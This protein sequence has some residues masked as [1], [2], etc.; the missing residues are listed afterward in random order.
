MTYLIENVS[1]ILP[2]F[3]QHLILTLSVIFFTLLIGVP[4]GVLLARKK[5]LRAPVL[6]FLGIVY[7]IPSLSFFILLLPVFGLGTRS[8][9]IA[10]T[11]Y[12]QLLFIRNWLTGLT[13]ID[14]SI[15]EAAKGMGM[16]GRRRFW[17]VEFPLSLPMFLAGVRLVALSSI[18]IG[19]I[20]AFIHAG[21]LGV[22]L[23]Q[24]VITANYGKIS[25]GA[26]CVSFLAFGV[27][28]GI[29]TL[30]RFSAR[31]IRGG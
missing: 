24:G 3:W 20:A 11:A 26:V 29:H 16:T 23:F 19:T 7:T 21:G 30:E 31:R 25:A 18:G 17:L 13:T 12:A 15:L 8:A 6:G 10:L 22:L 2:L 9:I 1:T 14:P 4:L 28:Y 5:S 27:N